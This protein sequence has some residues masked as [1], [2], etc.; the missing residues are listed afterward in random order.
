MLKKLEAIVDAIGCATEEF[1]TS[2]GPLRGMLSDDE[3]IALF[4]ANPLRWFRDARGP[5][6]W[7]QQL[8]NGR[9]YQTDDIGIY[10][11]DRPI[12]YIER[13]SVT[14]DT[15][16]A[17]I[18]HIAVSKGLEKKGLGYVIAHALR[19]G[20]V[21]NYQVTTIIFAEDHTDYEAAGYPEF[22]TRLGA[23]MVVEQAGYRPVWHWK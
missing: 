5:Y 13:F 23:T 14:K 21:A 12:G 22:F 16:T 18:G 7:C 10:V 17:R 9:V 15:R 3:A 8:T 20:L 6:L 2:I 4:K 11:G 19:L 1:K